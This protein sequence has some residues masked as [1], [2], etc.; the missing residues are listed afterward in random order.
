MV[1]TDDAEIADLAKKLGA[2]V[3]FMRSESTS[4]DFA[5]TRDV[6]I[7]VLSEYEKRGGQFDEFACIYPCV[8]FLSG[9]TLRSA[10]Q[11]FSN[12]K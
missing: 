3:P 6:L 7:E 5:T 9:E 8:P 2:Q 12:P 10:H 1:S 4:N 11:E